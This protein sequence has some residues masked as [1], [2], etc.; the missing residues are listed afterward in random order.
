MKRNHFIAFLFLLTTWSGCKENEPAAADTKWSELPEALSLDSM[1]QTGFVPTLEHPL[2]PS[3]NTIY[4]AALLYAWDSLVH[5]LPGPL[6]ND[7][8]YSPSLQLLRQ[9]VTH[10]QSLKREEYTINATVEGSEILVEAFFHK[11]LPFPAQLEKAKEPLRFAGQPVN[12]FG[13][14]GSNNDIQSFCQIL[15]YSYDDAFLLKITPK[16]QEHEIWLMICPDSLPTLA[17]AVQKAR[18]WKLTGEQQ[19]ADERLAWRYRFSSEDIFSIPEIRFNLFTHYRDLEG[20]V[21]KM[22]ESIRTIV[23]AYQ[24]T[25][26]ILNETGAVAES[27]AEMAVDSAI[28]RVPEEVPVAKKMIFDQPFYVI[29]KRTDAVNPYFVMRVANAELLVKQK[30]K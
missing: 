30:V 28:A 2:D 26:F 13:M 10:Q 23:T 21:L 19:A 12:A 27:H 17:A 25:G 29:L 20:Q 3:K 18:E 14:Y 22:P 24:R 4:A 15:Y 1:P 9:S 11:T 8:A 5:L 7:S 6:L 16:E